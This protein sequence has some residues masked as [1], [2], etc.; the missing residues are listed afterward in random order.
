MLKHFQKLPKPPI[1]DSP[2]CLEEKIAPLATT[3]S[4]QKRGEKKSYAFVCWGILIHTS[5]ISENNM[6]IKSQVLKQ[7]FFT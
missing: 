7:A 6:G 1:L 3:K 2:L 5:Y 4:R